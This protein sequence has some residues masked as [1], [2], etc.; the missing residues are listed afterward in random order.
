MSPSQQTIRLCTSEDDVH[1]AYAVTGSGPALVKAANYLTHLEHD[2]PVWS[3]WL[4]SFSS[5][6]KL[7]RYD[8]RGSGLSD[9]NVN[10]FSIDAWVKDLHAVTMAAGLER[11][12]VLGISQGASV[13]VAY[14]VKYPERVSRLVLYGGYARGRL[15]RELTPDQRLE[16]ETMV[17]AIRLGWGKENPAFRQLFSSLLMPEAS[18]QQQHQLNELARVSATPQTAAAMENAFYKINVESLAQLVSTPTLIL[19]ARNDMC[20]PF[21]EGRHL[22]AL[23][24]GAEF[25]PLESN[26]HILLADEPAWLV[27]SDRIRKFL[28]LETDPGHEWAAWKTLTNRERD[29]LDRIAQGM[30]NGQIAELLNI[31]EKTVRNHIT[32]VFDKLDVQRRAEAIVMA[33]NF[34]LGCTI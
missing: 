27:A 29:I 22:A 7:L 3:H 31:S 5:Y 33:R 4:E 10:E 19:H 30:S 14:A 32:H 17:N 2:W 25:V 21:E 28:E 24:P 26:N 20:I 34:G 18:R 1:L 23:I 16:A 9:R 15:Q 13:A 11:F 6:R 12:A 8:E